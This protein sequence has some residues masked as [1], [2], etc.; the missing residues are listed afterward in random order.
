MCGRKREGGEIGRKE[1]GGGGRLVGRK[2]E[3]GEIG[4]KEEGGGEIGRKEV[5][6]VI[7]AHVVN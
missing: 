1:E 5:L 7:N 2:R 6:I 3:G 4:R